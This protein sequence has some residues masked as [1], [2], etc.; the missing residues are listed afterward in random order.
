MTAL[1]VATSVEALPD[2]RPSG[3]YASELIEVWNGLSEIGVDI[4]VAT[5]MGG[6]VPI[7]ARRR[8]ATQESFFAGDGGRAA[9]HAKALPEVINE[10]FDLVVV[11][12]GHAAM[13]D[14]A[15]EPA[16]ATVLHA[17]HRTGGVIG[18]VC[19]GVAGLL[20]DD[21]TGEVSLVS[22]RRVAAFTDDEERAVGMAGRMP[23]LS[24][25]LTARGAVHDQGAPFM[26]HVVRDARL[27]TGQ[28]PAST[29]Q[30]MVE[31]VDCWRNLCA[32]RRE[33]HV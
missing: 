31:V 22:G 20:C 33:N 8:D 3:A 29:S 14:L 9:R 28:N 1:I 2:G 10:T 19:H 25:A 11:V 23:S 5:P 17:V 21:P 30:L 16:L 13:L 27:V 26:P 12:G 18:A 4:V 24:A 32:T 6:E 7:E 15:G